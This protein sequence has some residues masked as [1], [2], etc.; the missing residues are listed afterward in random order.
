MSRTLDRITAQAYAGN[1][2]EYSVDGEPVSISTPLQADASQV[3]FYHEREIVRPLATTE[4]ETETVENW[5]SYQ[6]T[7]FNT[8]IIFYAQSAEDADHMAYKLA[9]AH[10]LA[11][12]INGG[13]MA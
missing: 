1:A 12:A 8:G 11:K 9:M 10:L 3:P 5:V 6:V 4:T 13:T 2:I 7:D